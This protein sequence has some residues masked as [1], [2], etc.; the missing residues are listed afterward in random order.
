[1]HLKLFLIIY[2]NTQPPEGGC[3]ISFNVFNVLSL[4]QHTATRRWL[5]S[6]K[7]TK[8]TKPVI[9]THS[10]P[11]V[12]AC[13]YFNFSSI[14]DISTHSHPKVAALFVILCYYSTSYFNTQPPEGG[15]FPAIRPATS[16]SEFQH[17]ATRRWLLTGTFTLQHS[18]TFQHTATRR[19]L[20]ISQIWLNEN[21]GISTHS[22][23]KVAA[24]CLQYLLS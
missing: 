7:V 22:H 11:K 21:L 1:M 19:W 2:F 12:A 14:F 5:Q 17:T 18:I 10:H 8:S 16:R 9:S 6:I 15:C 20:H 24:P 3:T 4:F 23:P 13:L